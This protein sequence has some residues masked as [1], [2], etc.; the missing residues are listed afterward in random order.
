V[1]VQFCSP[2]PSNSFIVMLI[3]GQFPIACCQEPMAVFSKTSL[4]ATL[5]IHASPHSGWLN[6]VAFLNMELCAR[7]SSWSEQSNRTKK[8]STYNM[9]VTAPTSH[10]EM[11]RLNESASPNMELYN[12]D[13]HGQS[14]AI[15]L[16]SRVLTPCSSPLQRPIQKRRR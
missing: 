15:G 12:E 16:K 13:L 4:E 9:V 10:P 6:S 5:S 14:K 8:Q 11:S 7:R 1:I 3:L 2:D